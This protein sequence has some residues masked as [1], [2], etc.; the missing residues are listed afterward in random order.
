[1]SQPDDLLRSAEEVFAVLAWH[2]LDAV[3]IGAVALTA[4]HYVRQTEDLDLGVNAD[5]PSL[6][7][8]T[9]P[10]SRRTCGNPIPPIPSGA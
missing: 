8:C 2:R 10:D 5:V 7:R 4:H 9:R 3:V 6:R 1:M